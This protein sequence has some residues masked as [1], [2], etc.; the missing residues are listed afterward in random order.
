MGIAVAM[1][2]MRGERGNDIQID[3]VVGCIKRYREVLVIESSSY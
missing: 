3:R 1:V 2:W